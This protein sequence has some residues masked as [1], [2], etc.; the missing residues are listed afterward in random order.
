[1]ILENIAHVPEEAF[2][3][4]YIPDAALATHRSVLSRS[5]RLAGRGYITPNVEFATS[6]TSARWGVECDRLHL[7]PM[8]VS[9]RKVTAC[10]YAEVTTGGNPM[11]SREA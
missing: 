10:I 6:S 8:D 11:K 4:S 7:L 1:M 2:A 9:P 5:S 3:R